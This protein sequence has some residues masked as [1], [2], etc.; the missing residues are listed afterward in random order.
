LQKFA[1]KEIF[2]EKAANRCQKLELEIVG[3]PKVIG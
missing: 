1:K 2:Y 3:R